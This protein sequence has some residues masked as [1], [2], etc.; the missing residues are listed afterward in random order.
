[1]PVGRWKLR[2]VLFLASCFENKVYPLKVSHLCGEWWY[3]FPLTS[4]HSPGRMRKHKHPRNPDNPI[5][6][7]AHRPERMGI[8]EYDYKK[9]II[10]LLDKVHDEKLLRRIWRLLEN[11]YSGR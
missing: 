3:H 10:D 2:R 1:M 5:T 11:A 8:M 9:L 7:R 6:H 4:S